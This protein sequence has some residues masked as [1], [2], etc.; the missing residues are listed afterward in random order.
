MDPERNSAPDWRSRTSNLSILVHFDLYLV[1]QTEIQGP[2]MVG[3]VVRYTDSAL[4]AAK[5]CCLSWG[6]K[7]FLFKENT[8]FSYFEVLLLVQGRKTFYIAQK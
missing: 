5:S 6:V 1:F 8:H 2:C 3:L 4:R 7:R